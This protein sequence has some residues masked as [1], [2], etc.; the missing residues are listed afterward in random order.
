MLMFL[1]RVDL[2]G[3]EQAE[4]RSGYSTLNY[5]FSL[6]CVIDIYLSKSKKI[7]TAFI[8]YRKAFDNIWRIGLR[9]KLL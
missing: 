6:K 3:G 8:D 9:R 4:F 1:T 7:F 2:I 5:D